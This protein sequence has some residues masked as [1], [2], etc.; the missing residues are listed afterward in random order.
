MYDI[1]FNRIVYDEM[2]EIS[3]SLINQREFNK[4]EEAKESDLDQQ[5]KFFK[6]N[7]NHFFLAI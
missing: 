7:I 4:A 5:D 2:H 1:H 6:K 3:S